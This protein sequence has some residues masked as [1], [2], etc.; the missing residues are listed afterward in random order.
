MN[1]E[2]MN[3]PR[4]QK[5][6]GVAKVAGTALVVGLASVAVI[7]IGASLITA[8]IVAVIS[9][10]MV[11]FVVPVAARTVALWRVNVITKLTEA[12]SE[13]TI[14]EDEQKEADRIKVLET[15]YM[16]SRAELEGAQEE[17]EKQLSHATPEEKEMLK[18]Q[19]DALQNIIDEAEVTLK[20]RKVDFAELQRVNKLYIAFHRAAGAMNKARGAERNPQ[21]LQNIE[22]ARTAIKTKMREAMAGKTIDSMN[23]AVKK[24]PTLIGETT[25]ANVLTTKTRK[26]EMINV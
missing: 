5:V 17:M 2:L 16:T 12:F 18:S 11:N 22:T 24:S 15:Q 7:A 23:L 21:E 26:K 20:Q 19:I 10:F 25:S 4:V 6:Q 3:D 9:L 8:S 14:R 13:E 1:Q